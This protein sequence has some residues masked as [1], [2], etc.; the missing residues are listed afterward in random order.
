M[1][2][3]VGMT[4]Y[5]EVAHD[6]RVRRAA[7]SLTAAGFEVTI[8]CLP[9]PSS[10]QVDTLDGAR[11]LPLAPSGRDAV[12]PGADSPF[13][14]V[15]QT[16]RPAALRR[17]R[18]LQAYG[19]SL[20]SWRREVLARMPPCDVWH[21]HDLFGVWV[22]A[23]LRRQH[24]GRLVYDSHELF[25]ESGSAVRLPFPGRRILGRLERG[26]ARS[27]DAVITVNPAIAAELGRRYGVEAVVVMN[28]PRDWSPTGRDPLRERLG[29]GD[30]PIV[31]YHGALSPGRGVEQLVEASGSLPSGIAV[32]L[33]G[34]GPLG[35]DPP[36]SWDDPRLAGRLF[37]HPA[38]SLEELPDWVASADVGVVAFQAANRNNYLASP[39]KLFDY[40][41]SG[42]PVVGSD[43]PEIRRLIGEVD[44]GSCV[45]PADPVRL[46]EAVVAV[47]RRFGRVDSAERDALRRRSQDRFAWPTQEARLLSVYARLAAAPR[48]SRAP[49]T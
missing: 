3:R 9:G 44:G 21:G 22:A 37:T 48:T 30:R 29:I 15:S 5:G 47:L 45:D 36:A 33:L 4:L 6:A 7:A 40:L 20:R 13:R 16:A 24:G 11:L 39:N 28:V 49:S 23:A 19:S 8:A 31:L 38:V 46:A 25:L 1:S 2:V 12:L 32:V 27:A 35:V 17:V 14:V 43:F 42:V 10:E 34:D 41:V 26:L 18:W